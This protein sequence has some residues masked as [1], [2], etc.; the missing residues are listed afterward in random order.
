MPRLGARVA[1]LSLSGGVSTSRKRYTG[2]KRRWRAAVG[3]VRSRAGHRS[4]SEVI[5]DHIDEHLEDLY[6]RVEELETTAGPEG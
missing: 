5:V 1:V 4:E 6:R 3:P 2:L